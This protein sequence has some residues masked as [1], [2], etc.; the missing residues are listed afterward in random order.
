MLSIA[1][2]LIPLTFLFTQ[3]I[4]KDTPPTTCSSKWEHRIK[5]RGTLDK[6]TRRTSTRWG[7]L[8]LSPAT[9]PHLPS[10]HFRPVLVDFITKPQL[11]LQMVLTARVFALV[12]PVLI[13]SFPATPPPQETA[14]V[15]RPTAAPSPSGHLCILTSQSHCRT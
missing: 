1:H 14:D 2:V 6:Q 8:V 11:Y 15:S 12:C 4:H 13:I 5:A 7:R 10:A 9:E 3:F